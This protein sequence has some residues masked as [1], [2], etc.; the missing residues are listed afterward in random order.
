MDKIIRKSLLY[1]SGVEYGDYTINHVIGC[2][3]GCNFPCYAFMLSKRF[4]RVKSYEEW[5]K[6]KI[7]S[8]S[9][10]ILDKEILKLKDKI[11]FV[12][13]SFMTDPFMMGHPEVA[14]LSLDIIEKLNRNGI[15]VTTLTKG[16][17]PDALLN[18]TN[19]DIDNEYG[20][21]LVSLDENFKKLYESYSSNYKDRIES[22]K[23]LHNAGFKT[24]VSIEPYPTPNIVNQDLKDILN[25]I[26]FVDKIV[27]GRLNYNKKVSEY[28]WYKEFYNYC[29]DIVIKFC[30]QH[31]IMY[32]IKDGTITGDAPY[33][34]AG[35][36]KDTCELFFTNKKVV[37]IKH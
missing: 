12:H 4:G 37:S 28:L 10:E 5:L 11:S 8:N 3:H 34:V 16:L 18:K 1:K 25:E 13:L 19:Y 20:I 35:Y 9:L 6:P 27:F 17:Y 36:K 21:T 23:K 2:S 26:S 31:N 15:K 29:S 7:V 22:L 24:W 30:E 32:H 14:K 33:I